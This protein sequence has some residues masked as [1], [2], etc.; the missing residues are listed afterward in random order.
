[1]W[2]IA[3]VSFGE[4]K[5]GLW[6]R[7]CKVVE[8]MDTRKWAKEKKKTKEDGGADR[9]STD[10]NR[11]EWGDQNRETRNS[12]DSRECAVRVR[13]HVEMGRNKMIG[14]EPGRK[15][16]SA[17]T[18]FGVVGTMLNVPLAG[19]VSSRVKRRNGTRKLWPNRTLRIN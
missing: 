6:E 2:S 1:M 10:Y 3:G 9:D 7:G 19:F 8:A 13:R 5:T 16:C 4:K 14:R 11:I 17:R 15:M 18:H 12:W